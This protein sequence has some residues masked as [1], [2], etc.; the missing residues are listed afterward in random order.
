MPY[1]RLGTAAGCALLNLAAHRLG[2]L[3]ALVACCQPVAV[4][5]CIGRSLQLWPQAGPA[6]SPC[7]QAIMLKA[8]ML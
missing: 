5:R 8:D 4:R 3:T 6:D 7:Y 1:H 2:R